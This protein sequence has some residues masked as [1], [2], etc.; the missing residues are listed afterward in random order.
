[1]PE[2]DFLSRLALVKLLSLGVL[3]S[4]RLW[5]TTV[6]MAAARGSCRAPPSQL[7]TSLQRSRARSL[8]CA[9]RKPLRCAVPMAQ[10]AVAPMLAAERSWRAWMGCVR[11][12]GSWAW[13][14]VKVRTTHES[15]LFYSKFFTFWRPE[16]HRK[17]L[18]HV[19]R[20]QIP[21]PLFPCPFNLPGQLVSGAQAHAQSHNADNTPWLAQFCACPVENS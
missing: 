9:A 11:R 14:P 7:T 12:A 1:M 19:V 13:H 18:G 16:G 4:L 5:H 6:Q 15:K 21:Q 3:L 10:R 20:R 8:L 2:T 17:F